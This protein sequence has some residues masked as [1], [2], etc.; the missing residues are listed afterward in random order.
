[1]TYPL[2]YNI[3]KNIAILYIYRARPSP[4]PAVLQGGGRGGGGSPEIYIKINKN[5][6]DKT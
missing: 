1:M 4:R 3:S 2:V 6:D 5:I